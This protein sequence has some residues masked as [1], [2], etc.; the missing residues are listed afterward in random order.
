MAFRITR[1]GKDLSNMLREGRIRSGI[2]QRQLSE[3]LGM[4]PAQIISNYERMKCMPTAS[5]FKKICDIVGVNFL[6]AAELYLEHKK[7]VLMEK[8]QKGIV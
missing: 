3:E 6:Q 4:G 2:S 8:M 5:H 7:E 1:P